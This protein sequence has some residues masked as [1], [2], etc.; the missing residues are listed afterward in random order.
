MSETT[1]VLPWNHLFVT[2]EGTFHSCC[3]IERKETAFVDAD[4]IKIVATNPKD[5][6]K[7]W[8][9][10]S[11]VQV[12]EQML[13]AEKP[14]Q[15]EV[16]Y[17]LEAAGGISH[18]KIMNHEFPETLNRIRE[19][20]NSKPDFNLEFLDLRFGNTCNLKCRMC[21]PYSSYLLKDEWESFFG[22]LKVTRLNAD[23]KILD[24]VIEN[25]Q[26]IQRLSCLGGE[27]F[28]M[29]E[30]FVF[31]EALVAK[32]HTRHIK[33][34][35]NSNMTVVNERLFSI[36]K[37]FREVLIGASV[38]GTGALND[39][40][41]H[42]SKWEKVVSSMDKYRQ[43]ANMYINCTIQ[44]YNIFS[45]GD[46]LSFA[47]EKGISVRTTILRWPAYLSI[48]ALPA[49]SK[50]NAWLYLEQLRS[51]F[52]DRKDLVSIQTFMM[53]KDDSSRFGAFIK[54]TN[55]LDQT[56]NQKVI[57]VIPELKDHFQD[58]IHASP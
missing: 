22:P 39:Y 23:R 40:I 30:V 12:R 24:E 58:K 44:I 27:P 7:A 50:N 2:N 13:R 9:S 29:D 10:P 36:W 52:P 45:L 19:K 17:S 15:C 56:R 33:L 49:D 16:C 37:N 14:K 21:A 51:R 46:L 18:R 57:D 20:P 47:E 3:I 8:S 34:T 43:H 4:G 42:P 25:S 1:C 5:M 35:F 48:Q 53:E 31:L 32:G 26:F 54:W 28:I 38:D 55:H 41:R 11:I 6:Q